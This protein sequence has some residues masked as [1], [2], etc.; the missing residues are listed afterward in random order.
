[1]SLDIEVG[2]VKGVNIQT[3]GTVS[4]V[5]DTEHVPEESGSMS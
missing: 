3:N 1:M 4:D 5:L 2:A